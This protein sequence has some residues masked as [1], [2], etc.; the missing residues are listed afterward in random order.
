MANREG[1]DKH[2]AFTASALYTDVAAMILNHLPGDRQTQARPIF[3]TIA[4]KWGEYRL[5]DGLGNSRAV[6]R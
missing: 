6:V 3:F 1:Q 5:D 4:D 2:R